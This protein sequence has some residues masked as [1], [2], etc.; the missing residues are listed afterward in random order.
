ML[1]RYLKINI[2]CNINFSEIKEYPLEGEDLK[3]GVY[4]LVESLYRVSYV[5]DRIMQIY[6]SSPEQTLGTS[7]NIHQG[8]R[9]LAPPSQASNPR[10]LARH[11]YVTTRHRRDMRKAR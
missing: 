2:K 1:P 4:A 11:I 5:V 6:N 3:I 7:Q 8:R 9:P 10:S